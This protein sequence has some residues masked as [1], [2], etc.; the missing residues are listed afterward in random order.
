MSAPILVL[1][2]SVPLGW[3]L[4]DEA[5]AEPASGVLA[6]L[7]AGTALVPSH[8][9]AEV[10]NGLLMALRRGRLASDSLPEILARLAVLPVAVDDAGAHDAWA[11]PLA[12]AL[13][14]GLTL[15]DALYLE[16][17][18]RHGLPLATFDAALRHAAAAV[19]VAVLP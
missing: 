11:E 2:A 7:A 9:R 5:R 19:G 1:D 8:W 10:G 4:P 3:A 17:A 14:T 6:S 18:T 15:Y 13:A 16:L 12:Q